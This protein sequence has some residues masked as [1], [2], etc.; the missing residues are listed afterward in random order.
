VSRTCLIKKF[1]VN[2]ME[3]LPRIIFQKL[4]LIFRGYVVIDNFFPQKVCDQLR[5]IALSEK[6]VNSTYLK[7]GYKGS[8]FDAIVDG[9]RTASLDQKFISD[10]KRR[11]PFLEKHNYMRSWSFIYNTICDGV[12]SHADPSTYN[13][14]VW[15]TP[16][17]CLSDKNKNGLIIFKKSS[18]DLSYE[19]YNG[20]LNFIKK[21]LYGSGYARIPYKFNRAVIFPGRMFHKTDSVHMKSGKENRR[22]NYTFLFE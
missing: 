5:K 2:N 10:I 22:I 20:N 12:E 19:Q 15:I 6:F 11:A 14:N 16:D 9:V 8:D 17:E 1:F 4:Q 21:Y 7:N 18:K 13:C 3:W